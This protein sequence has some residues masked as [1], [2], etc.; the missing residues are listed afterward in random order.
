EQYDQ[1]L[2]WLLGL[3]GC[4]ASAARVI[5]RWYPV[6]GHPPP[7]PGSALLDPDELVCQGINA[8][9][10]VEDRLNPGRLAWESPERAGRMAVLRVHGVP[11]WSQVRLAV[12]DL[13]SSHDA[14]VTHCGFQ[15]AVTGNRQ[16]ATVWEWPP[17]PI[18]AELLDRL[19]MAAD[20]L[21]EV[22]TEAQKA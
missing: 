13:W 18:R 8:L 15:K 1:H 22:V 20:T 2:E 21:R 5:H 14:I 4:A 7:F 16:W 17:V 11:V 10:G 19:A 12:I 6:A 9:I 3:A